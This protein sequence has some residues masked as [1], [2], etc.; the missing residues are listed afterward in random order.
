[1]LGERVEPRRLLLRIRILDDTEVVLWKEQLLQILVTLVG[2]CLLLD[3]SGA[4]EL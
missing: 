3:A 4:L 2:L 1:M